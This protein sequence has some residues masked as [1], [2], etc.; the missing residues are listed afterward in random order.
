MSLELGKLG[1]SLTQKYLKSKKYKILDTNFRL[2]YGEIDI[3][4][5]YH[6]IIIFIEVKSRQFNSNVA[7]NTNPPILPEEEFT[8]TKQKRLLRA[9]NTYLKIHKYPEYVDWRLDLIAVYFYPDNYEII[10][11]ENALNIQ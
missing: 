5:K 11:Y 6:K 3:V 7:Q 8:I 10:H 1:E 9:I 4:A 2:N